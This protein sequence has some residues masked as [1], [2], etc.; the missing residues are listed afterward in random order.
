MVQV[1]EL[2]VVLQPSSSEALCYLGNG[3]LTQYDTTNDAI[4]LDEAEISFRASIAME[5]KTISPTHVPDD[6]KSSQWWKKMQKTTPTTPKTTPIAQKTTSAQ[7]KPPTKQAA[8][9]QRKPVT[10]ATSAKTTVRGAPVARKPVTGSKTTQAKAVSKTTPN[11]PLPASVGGTRATP[12]PATPTPSTPSPATVGTPPQ[13]GVVNK[14]SHVPRLGL[15][16]TL[17][18]SSHED[19]RKEAQSLYREVMTMA[20]HTH[21]AY[22]ELGEMLVKTRPLDAVHV[23]SQYPFSQPPTF[24]DAY[25]HGEVSRLLMS[26]EAYDDPRLV[27]SMVAMGQ[28]L[29]IGVL[30]KQVAVLEN[31]FKSALLKKIYAGVHRKPLNDPD[32]QAFFKFKCW[33]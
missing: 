12:S 14:R 28:A 9:V 7:I 6:L 25:L 8:A 22:I 15:A 3:Q 31:K 20:P 33:L 32:L 18:K 16:R 24:D 4:W 23:Y 17:S 2:G 29:G 5:G 19:K 21:D 30:E 27:S 10:K 13:S 26:A 11:K 1:F